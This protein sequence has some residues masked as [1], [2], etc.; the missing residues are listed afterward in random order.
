MD[1]WYKYIEEMV[2]IELLPNGNVVDSGNTA[3]QCPTKL[4]A[5][6]A[7]KIQVNSRKLNFSHF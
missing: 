2:D 3:G 5:C 6:M 4:D 1:P 7:N